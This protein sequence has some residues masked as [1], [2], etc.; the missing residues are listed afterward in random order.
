MSPVVNTRTRRKGRTFEFLLVSYLVVNIAIALTIAEVAPVPSLTTTINGNI[1]PEVVW[2]K[3]YG[4]NGDDRVF[5]VTKTD[6]GYLVVGSSTSNSKNK[7]VAWVLNLGFD[8]EVLWNRTYLESTGGEFRYALK[9]DDT[10]LLVGNVLESSGEQDGCAVKIDENGTLLWKTTI[11]RAGVDKL[12]SATTDDDDFILAGLTSSIDASNLDAWVIRLDG[13]GNVLWNMTYGS[14]QDDVAR[15]ISL[16]GNDL[17]VVCGYTNSMGEG[18]YDFWIFELDGSGKVIWNRTFG[19]LRSDKAY[20]IATHEQECIIVG[21]T[22]SRGAGNSDA[23]IIKV[24]SCGEL[25]WQK[26]LG[27]LDFDSAVCITAS[28]KGCLLGGFSLSFGN[29]MRDIW[30][31]KIDLEGNVQWSFALGRTGYEEAYGIVGLEDE[32]LVVGGWTDFAGQGRYDYYVARL[33]VELNSSGELC[34]I[35]F[36]AFLGILLLIF[37]IVVLTRRN[38]SAVRS[39]DSDLLV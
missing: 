11:D 14:A 9:M 5:Y 34:W 26:T 10:F 33:N 2:E 18:D 6:D 31:S 7:T 24:N 16:L 17:Y 8:G 13:K 39:L 37:S 25:V 22:Q 35:V 29:G 28:G 38:K 32:A 30:L 15:G 1:S 36:I 27:G 21:D 23:W 12:F 3:T 20:A 4:G 19:G